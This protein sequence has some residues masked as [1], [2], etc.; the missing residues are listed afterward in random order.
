MERLSGL[1]AS[2]LY[3]ETPSLHMHTL[4]YAVLDVRSV[5]ARF[6]LE[7]LRSEL[8]DRLHL[9]PQ[10]RRRVV[11]VPFGLHHPVWVEDIGFRLEDRAEAAPWH[12]PF[13]VRSHPVHGARSI[14]VDAPAL[15]LIHI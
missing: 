13:L 12:D 2:F 14:R 9:L 8:G 3:N 15:S 5:E 7:R 1:D 10:F 11:E 4:K 6:S